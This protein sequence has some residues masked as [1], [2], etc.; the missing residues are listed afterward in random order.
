MVQ[1]SLDLSVIIIDFQPDVE[2]ILVATGK[3]KSIGPQDGWDEPTSYPIV[4][5]T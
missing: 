3:A 4:W 2:R 5:L 1:F